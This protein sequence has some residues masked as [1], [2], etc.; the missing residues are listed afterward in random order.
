M[1]KV[2]A[3]IMLSAL[4]ALGCSGE[5]D[6]ADPNGDEE[7]VERARQETLSVTGGGGVMVSE[8]H[9][10][11]IYIGGPAPMGSVAGDNHEADLGPGA[12]NE[13]Q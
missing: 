2:I 11:S 6:T 13:Q 12:I 9:Q 1:W 8:G 3:G 4:I 10:L 5:A 7:P